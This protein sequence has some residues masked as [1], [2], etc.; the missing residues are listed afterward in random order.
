MIQDELL[1]MDDGEMHS[2][3]EWAKAFLN[4]GSQLA[5]Q[6]TE[7]PLLT[8]AVLTPSKHYA[9]VLAASGVIPETSCEEFNRFLDRGLMISNGFNND[10][11]IAYF[12]E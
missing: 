7:S 10:E 6:P 2:M 4:L 3:P 5:N 1:T 11:S 9:A 8:L 12:S